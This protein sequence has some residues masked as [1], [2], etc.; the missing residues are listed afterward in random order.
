MAAVAQTAVEQ[1]AVQP[2]HQDD[3]ETDIQAAG[4]EDKQGA[5]AMEARLEAELVQMT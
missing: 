4:N 3:A 2:A 5:V 1:L